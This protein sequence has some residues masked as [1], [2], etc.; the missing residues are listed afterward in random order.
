MAGKGLFH[1]FGSAFF[2]CS[3]LLAALGDLGKA[4][5][6][7][8]ALS[9]AW[10]AALALLSWLILRGRAEACLLPLLLW[11][12]VLRLPHVPL[13]PSLSDDL[14]RYVIDGWVVAHLRN[15]YLSRPSEAAGTIPPGLHPILMQVNHPELATIY[16]PAAE[17]AF[18][19]G[20]LIHPG[21]AGIKALLAAA[22]L[23][24]SWILW[25]ISPVPGLSVLYAWSPLPVLE[26]ASSGHVDSL[27]VFFILAGLWASARRRPLLA[28]ALLGLGAEVKPLALALG[29]WLLARHSREGRR[30]GAL[31]LAGLAAGLLIPWA[32]YTKGFGAW[33]ATMHTY[34]VHWEFG[35]FP[36]R[37]IREALGPLQG[38][39]LL[40]G[41]FALASLLCSRLPPGPALFGIGTSFIL[42]SPTLYPWYALPFVAALALAAY[43]Q[44]LPVTWALLLSYEVL[45]PYR[46]LGVWR[47]GTLG[48]VLV[49]LLASSLGLLFFWREAQAESGRPPEEL[50]GPGF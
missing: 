37:L 6:V 19:L 28:G 10:T 47:E 32:P 24:S 22:D 49:F 2:L 42:T 16:P 36:Y 38:R 26:T 30:A 9:A 11:A 31:A 23:A 5:P 46:Y 13:A 40:L 39:A 15:P 20:S 21:P 27:L 1:L 29:P 25:R 4:L 44:G 17:L 34:L 35:S 3:V 33:W 50:K 43:P 45:I 48:P 41:L 8:I 7:L 18:G 12:L 14:Y